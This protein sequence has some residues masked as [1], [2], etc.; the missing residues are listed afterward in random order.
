MKNIEN[1]KKIIRI[2]EL[3]YLIIYMGD[4]HLEFI[5]GEIP[6]KYGLL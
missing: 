6:T 4:N 2:Q 1:T 3:E 5:F